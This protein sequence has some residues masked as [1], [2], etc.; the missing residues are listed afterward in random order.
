MKL[1]EIEIDKLIRGLEHSFSGA[2]NIT[3]NNNVIINSAYGMADR[4]N[5]IANEVDTKFGVASV[6][7]LFTSIGIC[8]LV[9][10]G[11][12]SFDTRIKNCLSIDFP[13]LHP[14]TTIHHL[15]THTSGMA[16]YFDEDTMEDYAELWEATPMYRIREPKDFLTMFKDGKGYFNPGEKFRYCNSGYITLGLIIEEVTKLK[17]IEYIEGNILRKY[18]LKDT[19]FFSLDAL[20]NR[21]AVGYIEGDNNTWRTNIYSIPIIGAS[22]GGIFTTTHDLSILWDSLLGFKLLRE[23][24]I[25]SMLKLHTKVNNNLYYGYGVWILD[26]G[27]GDIR[28]FV[29][30]S[31]PG[32]NSLSMVIPQKGVK[33][34]LLSNS[35]I[36]LWELYEELKGHL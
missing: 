23:A 7:K 20:P 36:G 13:H 26:K 1:T 17:Y 5:S 14:D 9:E 15:L 25:E 24:T 32:V 31:D 21:T 28:Y 22:D 35:S 30:G 34:T 33:L 2:I 29:Q 12:L 3:Q 4:S 11:R 10:E 8:Q 16:D 27:D 19:G 6:T 18:N